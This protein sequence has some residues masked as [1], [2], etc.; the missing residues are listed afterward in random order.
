MTTRTTATF[1]RPHAQRIERLGR[2]IFKQC[3][4]SDGSLLTPDA[5][6]WTAENLAEAHRR[7]VDSPAR[8]RGTFA[9]RLDAA[10]DGASD[11]VRQLL[12]EICIVHQLPLS[13]ATA[14]P[15]SKVRLIEEVLR[16]I[17]S[18]A[19][20]PELLKAF[21]DGMV[22]LNH[23]GRGRRWTQLGVIIGFAEHF[24]AQPPRIRRRAGSDPATL[25]QL[26]FAAPSDP[27]PEQRHVLLY[28]LRPNY[29]LPVVGARHRTRL[30]DALAPEYLPGG[31]TDDLDADL[32][33]IDE[34]V[35]RHAGGPVDY[36]L[37]PWRARWLP[38]PAAAPS[39][40]HISRNGR[41]RRSAARDAVPPAPRRR[42]LPMVPGT[43]R[44]SSS[45]RPPDR[46]DHQGLDFAA[47]LGTPIYAPSDGVMA[48]VGI[49]DDP[50]GFGSWLVLD[51]QAQWG[52]DFVFGHMPPSSF[53]NPDTGAQWK[54]NDQ[55]RAGQQL[56]VVGNEGGS[57]GPHLHFETWAAPGR[58]GGQVQDPGQSWIPGAVDPRQA[59]ADQAATPAPARSLVGSMLVDYSAG[60]PSANEIAGAGFVGAV[61]YVSDPRD[62][63]MVGK[64]L[65]KAEA[66]DLRSHGLVVV[67][68]FQ[69]GKR[70]W[71]GGAEQGAR[72]AERG[73]QLHR[74]AG[75]PE[76][77]VIYVSVDADP[78]EDEWNTKV[79]PYLRAWQDRLG[80]ERLGVYCNAPCIDRAKRDGLG[81]YF[82]QHN[83][84]S[85]GRVH[86]DAHL[87]QFEI[88]KQRVAGVGV[89]RN[90]ILKDDFGQWD[91]TVVAAAVAPDVDRF[92]LPPGFYWGPLDGPEESWS[93]L[94]GTEPQYS[95]DGL[96]RWQDKLGLPSTGV[97]DEVTKAAA[98]RIQRA[99]GWA[100]SG[101]VN[102][103]EWHAVIR[104][105]WSPPVGEH[106]PPA[107]ALSTKDG[108]AQAII[109]EGMRRNISPRGIKIA[110]STAL[111]ETNMRMYANSKDQASLLLPHDAVGSDG[112]SVGLFQ[113]QNFAEWKSLECR[114]DAACSAGTF[115][116]HLERLP[117]DDDGRSPGSVAQAVQRSA[118][119]DRYD[120][121]FGEASGLFD[122]L[123]GT[124][125]AQAATEPVDPDRYPLPP[126][127][128]W[129]PMDGPDD[130]WSNL[131]GTEPQYSKDGL[132]RW[133]QSVGVPGTGVYDDATKDAATRM[134]HLFGWTGTG[135]VDG[136]EWDQVIRKG[137]SLTQGAPEPAGAPPTEPVIATS[138]AVTGDTATTSAAPTGSATVADPD[139]FPLPLGH[140]WGP[141]EDPEESWSNREGTDLQSS[142]DGLR[143]WQLAVGIPGTGVYDD[144]TK[145]AAVAMQRAFGWQI[146]GNVYQG[147][148]SG[149]IRPGW[150]LP[151]T[152][153]PVVAPPV[154]TPPVVTPV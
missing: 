57:T 96:R 118:F 130:S 147:E 108:Y 15:V 126:G 97:F 113:Q 58:F 37:P 107:A 9:A 134:Q 120:Q 52:L 145:N 30:R 144:A 112:M 101:N 54:V 122:R 11:D 39:N 25:R 68:N 47:D 43:Y 10:L 116:E 61:R 102:E 45:F 21:A 72:D 151:T 23:S 13:Q 129:G 153:P 84:G 121:R 109:A 124:V 80:K 69:F 123:I 34:A 29:F 19:V 92:P 24:K 100:P 142:I 133:Q 137:W 18:L 93:N 67:S 36:Y 128:Y 103:A 33:A 63:W 50:N 88:D 149:V 42:Y 119:P 3:I 132:R 17:P 78:T 20:T 150:R 90:R 131:A 110:L 85:A 106:W 99:M 31:E 28:L 95:T 139:A 94:A 98:L 81:T 22:E 53:I 138:V 48:K 115:Y 6:I 7:V 2:R 64:P 71:D 66:D 111:V 140:Y 26:V 76:D 152:Q 5:A 60:V 70:D 27:E 141:P 79:A 62:G 46:P 104:D 49:R 44:Q 136:D 59:A 89:D 14:K 65:R 74:E 146:S 135:I 148:W 73:T 32:R 143:R 83:W 55:V 91:R 38:D 125:D 127:V 8:T 75:G 154:V 35:R 1:G 41:G 77:A 51:A 12:A 105:G 86:D 114:M 16:P 4:A 82:W 56:A 40:G 117:Y 87:H